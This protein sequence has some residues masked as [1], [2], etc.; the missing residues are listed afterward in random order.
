MT[1]GRPLARGIDAAVAIARKRGCVMKF[2]YGFENTCDL[3]IRTAHHI[4]LAR[5]RR[6]DKISAS[7]TEIEHASRDII[8]ELRLFPESAQI[9]LEFWSY[10]RHGTYRFFRISGTGL[11]EL[12]GDGEPAGAK[13]NGNIPAGPGTGAEPGTGPGQKPD[14]GTELAGDCGKPGV[15]VGGVPPSDAGTDKAC[16][17][18]PP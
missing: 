13:G 9:F 11:V 3:L 6:M 7:V 2:E 12:G 8:A 10:S 5:V 18:S 17:L 14:C 4:V 16:S 1:R 15:T